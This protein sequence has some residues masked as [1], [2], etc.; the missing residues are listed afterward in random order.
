MQINI[1]GIKDGKPIKYTYDLFDKFDDAT[2]TISMARTTGYTA[3]STLRMLAK[4]LYKEIGISPPEFIGRHPECTTFILDELRKRN[5]IV[6]ES[7][8]E[9]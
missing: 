6:K 3:T 9:I 7:V 5:V 8:E 1:T 2:S 4:G